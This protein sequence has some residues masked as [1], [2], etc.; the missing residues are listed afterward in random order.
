VTR[1]HLAHEIVYAVLAILAVLV[2]RRDRRHGLLA[3]YIGWMSASDIFR[4]AV[5][6]VLPATPHPRVGFLRVMYHLE[7]W[8]VLSWSFLF[9]A[10][11]VHYFVQRRPHFVLGLW[12]LVTVF[13]CVRYPAMT[14]AR[15]FELYGHVAFA[16]LL[17]AGACIAWGLCFKPN[18][19]VGLAHLILIL[20]AATDAALR[21]KPFT[22]ILANWGIMQAADVT[23]ISACCL[24]H[25]WWLTIRRQQPEAIR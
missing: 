11:C 19:E 5:A 6:R 4:T 8:F 20:Y 17:A 21:A 15:L 1:L 9:V 23:L 16:S 3:A 18:L 7:E 25:V 13:L 24:A 22:A 14:G 10:C 2:W 12:M